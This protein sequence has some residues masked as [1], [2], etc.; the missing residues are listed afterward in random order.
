[1]NFS[2]GV[3]LFF[4]LI[5][6]ACADGN[7]VGSWQL[8]K[9]NGEPST[10]QE[11]LSFDA[12]GSL[13]IHERT[14]TCGQKYGKYISQGMQSVWFVSIKGRE[15]KVPMGMEVNDD[16]L[17]ITSNPNMKNTYH[18]LAETTQP[19]KKSALWEAHQAG[20]VT[21]KVPQ[22]WIFEQLVEFSGEHIRL[23]LHSPD[24]KKLITIVASK[25]LTREKALDAKKLIQAT[26]NIGEVLLTKTI[27]SGLNAE[28]DHFLEGK[29]AIELGEWPMVS[30]YLQPQKNYIF[31]VGL[32][33]TL[34]DGWF[35]MTAVHQKNDDLKEIIEIFENIK[36]NDQ[37]LLSK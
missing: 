6:V 36:I 21:L 10:Q 19:C 30:L 25:K 26:K 1:M 37:P 5:S 27:A 3:S 20:V 22:N 33:S 35:F 34:I 15:V 8:I 4:C 11:I 2:I 12:H 9:E 16:L 7:L 28:N 31:D 18:R 29:G 17:L 32:G 13:M 23:Q 14:N 24:F